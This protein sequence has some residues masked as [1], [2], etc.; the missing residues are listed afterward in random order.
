MEN[1]KNSIGITVSDT[2]IYDTKDIARILGCSIPTAREIMHR[3]DFPLLA[4]G[5]NLKV[6]KPA[7]EQWTMAKRV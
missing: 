4:V 1:I 2:I 5:K 3:A 6:S 7:F